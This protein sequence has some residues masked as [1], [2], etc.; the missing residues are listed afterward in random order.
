MTTNRMLPTLSLAIVLITGFLSATVV[1]A[2]SDDPDAHIWQERDGNTYE[3]Q[4]ARSRAMRNYKGQN[5]VRDSE[6]EREASE[7]RHGDPTHQSERA[8]NFGSDNNFTRETP[9]NN[10]R[11]Y[12]RNYNRNYGR[13]NNRDYDQYN[14]NGL[15]DAA[16]QRQL[17]RDRGYGR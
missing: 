12:N 7:F 9:Q 10:D 2:R 3:R 14:D 8:G 16:Y 6:R 4:N 1:T 5:S 15:G 11:N 17:A 13:T